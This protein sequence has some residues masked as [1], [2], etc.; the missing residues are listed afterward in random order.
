MSSLPGPT[1]RAE[2]FSDAN[3]ILRYLA[4]VAPAL[5]LYGSGVLEETEVREPAE[6]E[7]AAV[8]GR[9]WAVLECDSLCHVVLTVLIYLLYLILSVSLLV[10]SCHFPCLLSVCFYNN[11]YYKFRYPNPGGPLVRV[12]CP[13][14]LRPVTLDPCLGGTGQGFGTPHLSGGPW[15]DPR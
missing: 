11:I 4:R 5:A 6:Q 8:T 12:W 15:L 1:H 7:L 3:S 14:C 9:P 10:S 13:S 2:Q